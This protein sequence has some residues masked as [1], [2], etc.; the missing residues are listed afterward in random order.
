LGGTVPD[1][2]GQWY[3]NSSRIHLE[4]RVRRFAADTAGGMLVLDAGAG[5]SPYRRWFDHARYEAADMVQVKG[6]DAP[7]DYVCDLT[8][9]PVEDGRFDRILFNQVL[10]HVPDPPKVL[11]E[12]HRVLKPGGLLFCSVPLFYEE[13]QKP[14]D[15][16]RY[17]Q[18]ALRK[19][20]EEAGFRVVRLDWLEG[21]FGTVSYQFDQM[22][23]HLPSETGASGWRGWLAGALV[24]VTRLYA[25]LARGAFARADVRWKVTK[26]GHPKNYVVIAEKPEDAPVKSRNAT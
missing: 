21:Y 10:E 18:F 13:H 5:K 14:Y 23:R 20:F 22:V 2:T 17:T 9:I 16:F 3:V 7:L 19:L 12:L 6:A 26:T 8:S 11:A 25:R 15:Y 4:R 24:A 1:F